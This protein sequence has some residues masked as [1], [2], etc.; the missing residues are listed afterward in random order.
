MKHNIAVINCS[1]LDGAQT[2]FYYFSNT[3]SRYIIIDGRKKYCQ[4]AFTKSIVYREHLKHSF[5]CVHDCV[6][7]KMEFLTAR[8]TVNFQR[9]VERFA[10]IYTSIAI[11]PSEFL[12]NQKMENHLNSFVV[13]FKK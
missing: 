11:L 5:E 7:H 12:A 2:L 9:R 6:G 10:N 13:I 4:H 3:G 1:T 8:L